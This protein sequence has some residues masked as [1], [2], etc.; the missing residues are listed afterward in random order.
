MQDN[1]ANMW[2]GRKGNVL[3]ARIHSEGPFSP[4]CT[5]PR[6]CP[7][8]K[9]EETQTQTEAEGEAAC[10]STHPETSLQGVHLRGWYGGRRAGRRD[11][12][13]RRKKALSPKLPPG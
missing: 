7:Q 10:P 8:L 5:H 3:I 12:M 2:A 9:Q 4:L 13:G 6:S 1:I 11:T